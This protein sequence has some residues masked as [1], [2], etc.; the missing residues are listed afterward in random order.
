MG[1]NR[2]LQF[3]CIIAVMLLTV[4]NILPTLFFY[5]K[6]LQSPI[7][8]EQSD[9]IA[10]EVQ[11]RVN[12][13]EEETLQW[14]HSYCELIGLHPKKVF[15]DAENPQWISVQFSNT[16]EAD[17]LKK[18]LPRAV[19]MIAFTPAA[20]TLSAT[21]SDP[22]IVLIQRQIPIHLDPSLF[23]WHVK[24]ESGYQKII[25]D[26][27]AQIVYTLLKEPP[28][29]QA[30]QAM[31]TQDPQFSFGDK[32]SV[33][34]KLVIDFEKE[35]IQLLLQT[36]V[37]NDLL[38]KEVANL[39]R[40]CNE[41]LHSCEEGYEIAFHF[42]PNTTSS[43]ILHLDRLAE[44]E[45]QTL[46]KTLKTKWN[47]QHPDLQTVSIVDINTY[48]TLPL[49]EKSLSLVIYSPHTST[50]NGNNGSLY[51]SAN[52]FDRI[53]K[54][55]Q[56]HAESPLAAVLA[57][58][59]QSL[60]KILYHM[61]FARMPS[62][63]EG[64]FQFE[65]FNFAAPI[66]AATREDFRILGSKRYAILDL[67]TYEQRARAVNKIE[68]ALHQELIQWNEHYLS[69]KVNLDP[70]ARFD[71]PKPTHNVVW[72][73]FLLTFRKILRGDENKVIRW[74][75]DLSG[76]K[77]V[78]IEL[79]DNNQNLVETDSDI[80]QGIA[81]LRNRVNKLG[82]SEVSIRQVG[83]HVVLDFPGSQDLSAS[84]LIKASTMVFHVVNE[85]FAR[86]SPRIGE[87]ADRFLQGVWDEAVFHGKTDAQ[88]V[89][90]I[91]RKHLRQSHEDTK[92][93]RDHGL[94]FLTGN[95]HSADYTMDD[96]TSRIVIQR[97]TSPTDWHATHPLLIAFNNYTLLG[98][99]L[100]NIHSSYDPSK[101]NYLSFSIVKSAQNHIQAWTTRF[102][103]E[104]ILGTPNETYSHG[105][106]WRMAV[107]LNDTV[108]SSPNLESTLKDNASISG[109]FSQSEVQRLCSDLKAG[110]LTFTPHILSEKNV[111][112]ELGSK[113][114]D[115][116][117]LA[118]VVALLLVMGCMIAYYR[119]AGFVASIAV[120][121]N[122]LILWAV[123]QNLGATLTLAGIAGI[124]LTVGMSIDANVLVFERIKEEFAIS[125]RIS[126]AIQT[127]YSKAFSAIVD[128]NITT[129]IAA[130][131]LL[132]FDAGPTKSF[133]MNLIIGI[134]S[135]MFT[136]L[137]M[138]RFYFTKWAL[139]P[140]NTMLN[141]ANWMRKTSFDFLKRT[142]LAYTTVAIVM[143][144]GIGL[145][146]IQSSS[147]LGL[148]FTGGYSLYLELEPKFADGHYA[149]RVKDAFVRNGAETKDFV[150]QEMNPTNQLRIFFGQSM[151]K[152]G[153]PFFQM[154]LE[155]ESADGLLYKKNPRI[156]WLVKAV[157]E[158]GMSLSSST[159]AKLHSHWTAVSGQMSDTMKNQ[160]L[161]GFLLAFIGI[162][163]YLA[164][165]FV[166]PFAAAAIACLIHDV[167]MTLAI[168]GILAYFGVPIQ[169]DL[170]TIAALMTAVGYSLNDTIIIFD[171]IR[172]EMRL[173]P[174]RSLKETVNHALNFTLSR[175]MI[176]SGT[177]LLVLLALLVLGGASIFGFALV[178]TI[179][180]VFGT[181]SSWFIA[182]P[183]MLF[184]QKR[185]DRRV[186][187]ENV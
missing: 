150:V 1:K 43:L 28:T 178:M 161:F 163:I 17:R 114:R 56:E 113:D 99:D 22:K 85:K 35:R 153:K 32:N 7:S 48:A 142:K 27:A 108:I 182:A 144:S 57:S 67:S 60:H 179:G 151:E 132:N 58:D 160:A 55:Y 53:L 147:I 154:P 184:F 185:E 41:K 61:G 125:G 103:K 123:L 74:G 111:S 176:T 8:K 170:I 126:S 98:S 89:N 167:L 117:I 4:Y 127:G 124:I 69:S 152:N 149:Q 122:L 79:R 29:L 72:N 46:A 166:Y 59:L 12:H 11:S 100:E 73:N 75:L 38:V 169:I 50:E 87:V 21:D 83:Q 36:P 84:E 77:T 162:F 136:A 47:P 93:L 80:K 97:G 168:M 88:S 159:L 24:N 33:F 70:K 134:T 129:I 107:V 104:N 187:V 51:I 63:K 115:Q 86:N 105:R 177:T 128:S 49:E 140:K 14:I 16:E 146:F 25:T 20:L 3:L 39:S 18:Y 102:S 96:T 31:L 119:F 101:G 171:R 172:E 175:T 135:S 183:L 145:L 155:E 82:L 121:L 148:D 120:L 141:M 90:E 174:R 5:S 94:K 62:S 143:I 2:K 66:L 13:L 15:L 81:E 165:R 91:A 9:K 137:F 138:T 157:E 10:L 65:K 71:T 139:N 54:A 40:Q 42:L 76:G 68:T 118:T 45:I 64:V 44:R 19:A 112:P 130:L 6:P 95:D 116:G 92:T 34:S 186:V 133:A 164:F 158:S 131:I 110:S 37:S 26:R 106:G 30:L 23:S 78:E 109:S 156:T 181:L 173:M 52:G 180:V